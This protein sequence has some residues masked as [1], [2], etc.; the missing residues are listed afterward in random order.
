MKDKK[1]TEKY[2]LCLLKEKQNLYAGETAPYLVV[3]MLVDMMLDD[4]IEIS[5]KNKVTINDT[6]PTKEYN[7]KL[8]DIV[9]D[10]I[11]KSK[12]EETTIENIIEKVV[13][14]FHDKSKEIIEPLKEQMVKNEYITISHKKTLFGQKEVITVNEKT[15]ESIVNEL[16]K[17]FLED[18][19]LE[20]DYI[21]LGSLLSYTNI[22]KKMFTK[23][24]SEKLKQR[25]KEIEKTEI[26]K[27]IKAARD[28]IDAILTV[29]IIN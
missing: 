19:A 13:Y 5:E 3:S 9:K 29:I 11:S 18:G 24:E 21:L 7:E 14:S 26:G 4:N 8:Y 12:R 20:D 22:I 10:L 27:K 1:I 6:K 17:E 15:F 16:R 23:Y 28:L 2:A 25:L